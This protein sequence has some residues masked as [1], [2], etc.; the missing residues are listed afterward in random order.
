MLQCG[1]DLYVSSIEPRVSNLLTWK[2]S[3]SRYLSGLV[4]FISSFLI[5]AAFFVGTFAKVIVGLSFVIFS[6]GLYG[7]SRFLLSDSF[8]LLGP[9]V[10]YLFTCSDLLL[11]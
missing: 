2:L 8:M 5:G 6:A 7:G 10:E 9:L 3:V 1:F 11:L 4:I